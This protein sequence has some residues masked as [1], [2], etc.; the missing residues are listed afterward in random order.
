M[1]AFNTHHEVLDSYQRYLKSFLNIRDDQIRT[2]VEA[3]FNNRQFIP[4]A[5]FQFNP[6]FDLSVSMENLVAEKTCHPKMA[7]IF[8]GFMLYHHQAEAIRLGTKGDGFIVTSGTGSGKSLTYLA[9]IFDDILKNPAGKG[10]R[11]ILVY[12]M[13]A[14]INSQEN[15]IR[16]HINRY[17]DACPIRVAKYTGQEDE[18]R[19][20][21]IQAEKPNILLTN[22]MMLELI[23]TRHS[24]GWI[25]EQMK[26]GLKF[27]VFDEL[28][29]YRG[30]QGA[31]VAMLIRRVKNSASQKLTLIGTSATV[32]SE[33]TREEKKKTIALLAEKIFGEPFR[34]DQIISEKLK[35]CTDES[36]PEPDPASLRSC[37]KN[38]IP[39]S[40]INTDFSK[41]PLAIWLERNHALRKTET[42]EWERGKP[43]TLTELAE[44]LST[45]TGAE[46]E[47]CREAILSLLNWAE[48]LSVQ[49]SGK[50]PKETFL[51]F[52]I[53]QF[54]SPVGGVSVTLNTREQRKI[55]TT[56]EKYQVIDGKDVELFPVLFSRLSGYDF[57][58]VF[59]DQNLKLIEPRDPEYYPQKPEDNIEEGDQD[60]DQG[61]MAGYLI[62]PLENEELWSQDD[63]EGL[64]DNWFKKTKAG[65]ILNP[66]YKKRL[67]LKV[68]VDP[69]TQ[70]FSDVKTDGSFP[71]WFIPVRFTIDPTSGTF[72]DFKTKDTTKL[73]RIG[74]EGRSTATNVLAF[75]MLESLK[76]QKV[77]LENRKVMSFTDNRQDAS[78]QAGHFNDFIM[79]GRLRSA[80]VAALSSEEKIDSN[81]LAELVFKQLK[82]NESDYALRVSEDPAFPDP[83][84][85]DAIR[86]FI[87]IRLVYDLKWGWR[88]TLPNLEQVGLLH[89]GYQDTDKICGNDS[90]WA[91]IELFNCIGPHKREH[92]LRNLL[93]YFRTQFALDHVMFKSMKITTEN[94]LR[95]VLDKDKIWSLD[96]DEHID[97]PAWMVLT[98]VTPKERFIYTQSLGFRS[99]WGRY[100]RYQFLQLG[101]TLADGA[102]YLVWMEKVLRILKKNHLIFESEIKSKT[103]DSVN[104]Y[105]LRL[106]AIRWIKGD[107]TKGFVD[108]VRSLSSKQVSLKPNPFF[109]D[110]Y[111]NLN[112]FGSEQF[113]GREHTG[114]VNAAVRQ[115][116]E[117]Q[118]KEGKIA[119]L[120]CSPTMELGIDIA[121]LNLVHLRNVPPTPANYAQRS[122][123]AGRSG[124]TAL[125]YTYCSTGSPHDNHYFKNPN[126]MIAGEVVPPRLDLFNEELIL[127]HWNAFLLMKM[128]L[129]SV[130]YSAD[131]ILNVESY[132][133]MPLKNEVSGVIES[134]LNRYL[135]SWAK[136]F[137]DVLKPL[138]KGL[139]E[140]FGYSDRWLINQ[141]HTFIYRFN[142]AFDRWRSLYRYATERI[143]SAR[144]V[145]D[146][147][148][149]KSQTDK[150]IDAEKN[151]RLGKQLRENLLNIRKHKMGQE[152]EFYVFRYLASEGFLPGYNFTRLPIRTWVGHRSAEKGEFIS[153]PRFIALQEF[154]PLNLI[155]HNG[156]KF[157]VNRMRLDESE[158]RLRSL[159]VCA[160]SGYVF[161]D[162]EGDLVNHDPITRNPLKG[163][164][165]V[166]VLPN[167]LELKESEAIPVERISSEEEERTKV[168]YRIEQFISFP[169]GQDQL[170][171]SVIRNKDVDLLQVLFAP[172]ARLLSL[173]TGWRIADE[174]RKGFRM[175]LKTGAWQRQ[176]DQKELS[177]EN[178]ETEVMIFTTDQADCLYL[179]PVESLSLKPEGVF[180]LGFALKRAIEDQFQIEESELGIW[181]MGKP[182]TP[183]IM[184]YESS[185]GSLGILS[186]LATDGSQMRELFAKAYQICH[187]DPATQTDM[188]PDLAKATYEDLLSYY[189]QIHHKK[190]DR[191]SIKPALEL[192]M[193]CE[194]S[195]LIQNRSYEEQ[196]RQ[197]YE[198]IDPNS[199][200][201]SKLLNYLVGNGL[202]LPDEAQY[203]VKDFYSKP[204][205]V[206]KTDGGVTLV[207]CDG[208]VHDTSTNVLKDKEIRDKLIN[209]GYDVIVWRY[210]EPL[211]HLVTRRK[212]IFRK[213]KS[214]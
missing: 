84:N 114:Q 85:L 48:K 36:L 198:Q 45:R 163:G 34:P 182:E 39:T 71:A 131:E 109:Q 195:P 89:I 136:E 197:L 31:D 28:H 12:P 94:K 200:T 165:D 9:S 55:Y 80:L 185:E 134:Y 57:L 144:K 211:D 66:D 213:V 49:G 125:I 23:M 137:S 159:S 172:S 186:Q 103:G 54:I 204:D 8:K 33:G 164:K 91:D 158:A 40:G 146:D 173:N 151:E 25:R 97:N 184:I 196:A 140:K 129:D 64:P 206:Y 207:Y 162:Q 56:N 95:N 117:K 76:K 68:F 168:G 174:S 199:S 16:E 62:L 124:Q 188:R 83:G 70:T 86:D 189:N 60:E 177:H 99:Y 53:H 113:E 69:K 118:F 11:A 190:L 98:P 169:K 167:V 37:L 74:L 61:K 96:E 149:I 212:D 142:T 44:N 175:N 141:G 171:K 157:R 30:R 10:I 147:Y 108:E 166:K 106:D 59:L 156:S 51:P 133:A 42:G 192:L 203:L 58:T 65:M 6:S 128:S 119:A 27:L 18:T 87:F 46:F 105:Q 26:T 90:I 202:R 104:G 193:T 79:V 139:E 181:F 19:R 127:S 155:Y 126:K 210:D 102:T 112:K 107:T 122:G 22:Y 201:E 176:K 14:L 208:S 78:L 32:A 191:H 24:E 1:D 17:G 138:E 92:I 5:R 2:V 205:F 73:L 152:S 150:R 180:S 121:S 130:K 178:K 116:R 67:P 63:T 161:L 145:I 135:D 132:P 100:I 88:Y 35:T 194:I 101:L 3:A 41:F 82:L 120:F 154:G 7:D 179:Q 187:Y 209:A 21:E 77:D 214:K 143:N 110:F 13:N 183:N 81:N 43:V 170:K 160:E 20:N 47:P 148:Q 111:Q 72:H 93:T 52:K 75:S 38:G 50:R 115:E 29:T 153:R 15:E 123:R 4:D